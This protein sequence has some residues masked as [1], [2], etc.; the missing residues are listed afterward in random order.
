[1]IDLMIDLRGGGLKKSQLHVLLHLHVHY[2][3]YTGTC[4]IC[5]ERTLDGEAGSVHT[6]RGPTRRA[7]LG[8]AH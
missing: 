2:Y 8:V 6:P 7:A 4:I 3:P 1:M 5:R